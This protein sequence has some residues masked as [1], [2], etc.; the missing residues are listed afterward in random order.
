MDIVPTTCLC[1]ERAGWPVS[2]TIDSL[3]TVQL[4]KRCGM[5]YAREYPDAELLE[6]YYR[7]IYRDRTVDTPEARWRKQ[8]EHGKDIQSWLGCDSYWGR[9]LDVGCATGGTLQPFLPYAAAC[10]GIDMNPDF[11]DY[12][13]KQGIHVYNSKLEDVD[14]RYHLIILRH[15]LEHVHDPMDALRLC[16]ERIGPGGYLY[17]EVPYFYIEL[18]APQEQLLSH[19]KWHFRPETLRA[20]LEGA[21]FTVVKQAQPNHLRILGQKTQ[22][23]NESR[24]QPPYTAAEIRRLYW[25]C[26]YYNFKTKV[27]RSLKQKKI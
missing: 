11:L 6:V 24:Y 8:I 4:C 26:Q 22:A 25:Q 19:H 23:R 20:A 16:F 15:V 9:I 10:D 7:H 17:V 3:V 1:G 12:G 21:G 2:K 14:G 27:K 18:G 5:G 13:Q